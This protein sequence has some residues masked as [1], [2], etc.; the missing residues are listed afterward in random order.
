MCPRMGSTFTYM[1]SKT[2]PRYLL[3]T[4]FLALFRG[5]GVRANE[6]SSNPHCGL[7]PGR[8]TLHPCHSGKKCMY[9]NW[10]N[11]PNA[12]Y[13]SSLLGL[14]PR[15]VKNNVQVKVTSYAVNSRLGDIYLLAF[16]TSSLCLSYHFFITSPADPPVTRKTPEIDEREINIGLKIHGDDADVTI[17]CCKS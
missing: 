6:P 16:A 4:Y 9:C 15:T 12:A 5:C 2:S 11:L 17:I 3:R 13:L 1:I 7:S 10:D 8:Q 14:Q